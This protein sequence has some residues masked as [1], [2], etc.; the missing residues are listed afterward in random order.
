MV[1]ELVGPSSTAATPPTSN[2]AAPTT[3]LT[4]VAETVMAVP[5]L[6]SLVSMKLE[7]SVPP[8]E[9]VPSAKA[10]LFRKRYRPTTVAPS[11]SVST[12]SPQVGLLPK[13]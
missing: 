7:V 8:T 13:V 2:V 1:V 10:E 9:P 4:G 5:P 12:L 3:T 11:I 6:P